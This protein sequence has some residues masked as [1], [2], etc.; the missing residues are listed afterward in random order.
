MPKKPT[1][2]TREEKAAESH[3][4]VDESDVKYATEKRIAKERP[5]EDILKNVTEKR[6]KDSTNQRI[7]SVEKKYSQIKRQDLEEIESSPKNNKRKT[8]KKAKR[9]IAKNSKRT[10]TKPVKYSIP[11]IELKEKGYEFIITEKPQAAAKIA[12]S[13]GSATQKDYNKIPYYEVNRK[14]KKIVVGCAVGH[15]FTLKQ[16][17][18]NKTK[19]I[20]DISWTPNYLAKKNLPYKRLQNG[21][22]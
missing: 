2:P 19:P 14:G 6:V 20:F 3:F 13:L 5:K 1:K 9:K 11:N 7:T 16:N 21:I 8:R 18:T 22:L 17:E 12:A 4:N 15:L 10:T